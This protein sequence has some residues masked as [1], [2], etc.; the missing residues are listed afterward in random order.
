[1]SSSLHDEIIEISSS[2]SSSLLENDF[3]KAFKPFIEQNFTSSSPETISNSKFVKESSS[4]KSNKRYQSKFKKEWLSN[5]RFSTFLRECKG[6]PT[7]A[8]CTMC[9]IQFSVQNSGLGD[10][11]HHMETRKHIQCKKAAD[12][13]RSRIF[14]NYFST[15]FKTFFLAKPIDASHF[16]S[17][18]ELNRLSA[19][20]GALVFHSVRHSHSYVSQACTTNMIKKCFTDSHTAKN[21]SCSKTKVISIFFYQTMINMNNIYHLGSRDSLQCSCTITYKYYHS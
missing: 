12:A 7:K 17:T 3:S 4:S 5:S 13:N 19:V 2:S 15:V 9:N 20:E 21:I 18:S 6:D 11:N 10:V 16:I 8:L 1:M 14:Y